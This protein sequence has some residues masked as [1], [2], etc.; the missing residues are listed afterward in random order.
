MCLYF[1]LSVCPAI[2]KNPCPWRSQCRTWQ[3]S[4]WIVSKKVLSKKQIFVKNLKKKSFVEKKFLWKKTKFHQKCKKKTSARK[5]KFRKKTKRFSKKKV[6]TPKKAKIL[7]KKENK[8]KSWR[9][10][11]AN[12][13]KLLKTALGH[14]YHLVYPIR[15][16]RMSIRFWASTLSP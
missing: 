11:L 1:C 2:W 5:Q 7:E 3:G 14:F 9:I 15:R 13:P 12:V 4:D 6:F 16:K 10:N 8:P